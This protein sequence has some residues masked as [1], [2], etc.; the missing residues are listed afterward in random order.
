MKIQLLTLITLLSIFLAACKKDNELEKSVFI[1][2]PEN[3][4]LPAYSEWGYNT[5]GAYYDRDIFV[6]NNALVPAKIIVS[7]TSMTFML[8][9][10]LG[11]YEDYYNYS[12]M[13]L[14]FNLPGLTPSKYADLAIVNDSII[15]L[16]D[17][18]CLVE[19]FIDNVRY[20]VNIL[21]GE[22]NFHRVQILQ[23]DNKLVEA[24]LSGYFEFRAMISGKPVSI[25][26][27][28]F[29]V[30]IGVDNFYGN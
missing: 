9:G 13:I 24:I 15:D 8:D 18:E 1:N 29:D 16:T 17:S 6:S 26:D 28:R 19:V 10:Q 25:S 30:G 22:L 5:F 27:G 11:T 2:D 3:T 12:E 4:D 23:V 21:E 20:P 7:D 14:S